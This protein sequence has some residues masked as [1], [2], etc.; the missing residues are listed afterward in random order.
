MNVNPGADTLCNPNKI[1]IDLD[2][3]LYIP[4]YS[5][6]LHGCLVVIYETRSGGRQEFRLKIIGNQPTGSKML[7]GGD[8]RVKCGYIPPACDPVIS[9]D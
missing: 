8:T 3:G 9:Y 4:T 7:G 6:M 1:K 5:K 2:D